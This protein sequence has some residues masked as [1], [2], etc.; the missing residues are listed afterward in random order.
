MK[1]PNPQARVGNDPKRAA[2]SVALIR[3]PWGSLSRPS[4]SLGIIRSILQAAEIPSKTLFPDFWTAEAVGSSLYSAVSSGEHSVL[5][6][7]WLF[8]K[9]AFPSWFTSPSEQA[10]DAWDA[11]TRRANR[12]LLENCRGELAHFRDSTAGE[13]A[14]RVSDECADARVVAFT[15]SI[16][17]LVPSLA[18]A[19]RIKADRPAVKILLG[20]TQVAGEMGDEVL[21]A[22]PWI[23]AVYKGEAEEGMLATLDWL[24]GDAQDPPGDY[25]SHRSAEGEPVHAAGVALLED[26]DRSPV[27][28]YQAYFRQLETSE[29]RE[30]RVRCESIPFVSSRGCW[31]GEKHHCTFCGLDKDAMAFRY[32]SADRLT[33]EL[34]ELV[35]RHQLLTL[36]AMD[37]IIPHSYFESVLP[38]LR[39]SGLDLDLRYETKANLKRNHVRLYRDAGGRGSGEAGG[40]PAP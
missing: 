10:I 28:D 12:T 32:K 25:V 18:A 39:D 36:V 7:E 14:Q 37:N 11:D 22:A 8:S 2:R 24:F 5:L 29:A 16:N 15:C 3:M 38:R 40:A 27:P 35:G 33:D 9:A 6:P 1:I 4:P 30:L 21:H 17:Q 23:D 31:W 26:M 19:R 13:S 34:R 20:G